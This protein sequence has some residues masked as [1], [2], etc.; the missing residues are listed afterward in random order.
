MSMTASA[1]TTATATAL[2]AAAGGSAYVLSTRNASSSSASLCDE[3]NAAG[4]RSRD[5]EDAGHDHGY[6]IESH[7]MDRI[8]QKKYLANAKDQI[9][10]TFRVLAIDI[11]EMRTRAFTGSCRLSHDKVFLEDV[12]P[13]KDVVLSTGNSTAEDATSE[14][15]RNNTKRTKKLK[16]PQKS[17]VK[18]IVYCSSPQSQ[19]HIGVELLEASVMD[20]NPYKL[21]K[22][23]SIG[24]WE[25]DPGKYYQS[26]SQDED[27]TPVPEQ[28]GKGIVESGDVKDKN[29]LM[30]ED[31]AFVEME[32]P[33]NQYAWMEELRLRIN[34]HVHYDAP[35]EKSP[36][37]ERVLFGR[38]YK[39]TVPTVHRFTDFFIPFSFAKSNPDGVDS[40]QQM[41]VRACNKPH[42]VIANGAALQLVPSS[43]RL[44]QKLCKKAD[45]PL[46]VIQDP[47][48]WGGNTQASLEEA[49]VAMRSTVKNRV[50][51]NALKQ[52]GSLAFTRGRML[53]QAETEAKWQLKD[54]KRRAKEML[55]L[56]K[57]RQQKKEDWSQYD[58]AK[59]EKKLIDRNVIQRAVEDPET[60]LYSQAMIEVSEKCVQQRKL[61]V[62]ESTSSPAK[63]S[64]EGTGSFASPTSEAMKM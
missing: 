8:G 51:N 11:K 22:K 60:L 15:S 38:S 62:Q 42:A 46:F 3:R 32:A 17:L 54:K 19:Q 13:P 48:A 30:E 35:M 18:S 12:A 59:L 56:D 50:I 44:L 37:Y 55:G 57:R 14:S 4:Q 21:R 61:D 64:D 6:R 1:M 63:S 25:Y 16:V 49:L 20:L 7:L 28:A 43:L 5:D 23:Q 52:Q 26:K 29:K 39:T 34:G 40:K 41:N 9:P 2:M 45:V 31:S 24:T 36:M 47:R 10:S 33:W 53:G 27:G 58:A